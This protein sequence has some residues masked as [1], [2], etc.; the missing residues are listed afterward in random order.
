[1]STQINTQVKKDFV[2]VV[3]PTRRD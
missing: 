3:H 2:K 1:M